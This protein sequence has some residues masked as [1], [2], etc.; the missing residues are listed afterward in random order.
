MGVKIRLPLGSGVGTRDCTLA[1]RGHHIRRPTEN[2]MASLLDYFDHLYIINLAHR[3]DRRQEMQ[4]QLR[5]VGLSLEHERVSLFSAHTPESAGGFPSL[6]ARG[7]FMSHLGVIRQAE[8]AG[9]RRYLVA[10]DDLDFADDFAARWQA[11]H[12]VLQAS[13]WSLFYAT[14]MPMDT[15]P[16]GNGPLRLMPSNRNL[17]NTQFIGLQGDVIP[18]LARYLEAMLERPTG[19][20]NGGPMHVD[21]AFSWF[22]AQHP[23]HLTWIATPQFGYERPSRTDVHALPWYDRLPAVRPAAQTLRRWRWRLARRPSI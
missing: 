23:E 4:D 3:T 19:D 20:P 13:S 11:A 10:E 22:R 15:L 5:R 12:E 7:C 16:P 1:D 8:R 18:A 17:V 9:H 6:G 21:G 2:T 14:Y